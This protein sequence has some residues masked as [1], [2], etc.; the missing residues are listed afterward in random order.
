MDPSRSGLIPALWTARSPGY[1]DYADWA[2]DAGM[3][4]FK[5][6][7][8]IYRN[9]GQTF[10]D[11]WQNG[12]DGERATIGDWRLHLNT[13]FPEARLKNTVEVRACDAQR[14]ELTMAIP[15]LFT[16][17][18]YDARA[19]EEAEEL[20]RGFDY[21]TVE[22]A[23]PALVRD[24]LRANIGGAPARALAERLLDIAAGGLERRAR[25]DHAGRS[26]RSYLEPL[27]ALAERGACP[28]DETANG[29]AVGASVDVA[30]IV[31]RTRL[32]VD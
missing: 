4:L 24:A 19:L 31:A 10:R 27:V 23:R 5:R 21:A 12:Y 17:F 2:L 7:E 11:F 3:F 25:L 6:G 32:S 29:L 18:L 26:E 28:A 20:V 22:A 13:L 1:A 16:G 14:L 15:A 8:R 30:E 9:T